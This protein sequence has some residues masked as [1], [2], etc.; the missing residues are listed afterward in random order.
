MYNS[1]DLYIVS[2][3]FEGGPQS[4][5]ECAAT[6]TPIISTN[7]GCSE[8]YLSPESIFDFPSYNKS[9]PNCDFAFEKAK[10]KFLPNGF[11]SYLKMFEKVLSL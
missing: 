9:Q 5:P 6:K 1:L 7:V 3:R 2:S 11:D 8:A 10:E 4:I